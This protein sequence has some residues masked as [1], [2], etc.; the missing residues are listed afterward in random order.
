MNCAQP[1]NQSQ[2]KPVP[3]AAYIVVLL[4]LSNVTGN[5]GHKPHA[6]TAKHLARG[7]TKLPLLP[8]NMALPPF[9]KGVGAGSR[10]KA[11]G[12]VLLGTS[13]SEDLHRRQRTHGAASG[14]VAHRSVCTGITNCSVKH[15]AHSRVLTLELSSGKIAFSFPPKEKKP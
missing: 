7:I 9:Q 8:S 5:R 3:R 4:L 6:A 2:A 12:L 15:L 14:S 11:V 1:V 10:A 13:C